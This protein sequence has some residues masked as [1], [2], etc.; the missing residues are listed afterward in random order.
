[1]NKFRTASAVVGAV[2]AVAIGGAAFAAAGADPSSEPSASADLGGSVDML[3]DGDVIPSTDE[4]TPDDSASAAP[5]DSASASP[6][7]PAPTG[8]SAVGA[9][10]SAS[11]PRPIGVDA[12]AAIAVRVAGG[13]YV[14]S[15]ERET[16]HGR[17]VWDVDVIR[18]GVEH[19][20]DVDRSTGEVTRHRVEHGGHDGHGSDD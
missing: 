3:P 7:A 9:A 14:Q 5:D 6:T 17:A 8:S 19:D 12:A 18:D 4:P 15:I 20:I 2:A 1:M 11:S 10:P 13:G 16:E